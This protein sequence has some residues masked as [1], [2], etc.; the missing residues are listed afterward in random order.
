MP[1]APLSILPRSVMGLAKEVAK[2][3]L[4]RPVVGVSAAARTSDGRWLLVRRGDTGTWGLPGGTLEW[5]ETL[6]SCVVREL[7]EEA[8]VVGA[9]V[10]RLVGVYSR[11]DRDIRFHAVT[12]LV[13]ADIAE[14]TRK[15][16]N[17]LEIREVRLF[18]DDE[19]PSEIALG[20][21]DL[22]AAARRGEGEP[23]LE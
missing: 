1:F 15:P 6:R 20:M 17:P 19:L 22:L 3:L 10:G 13:T 8:G 4:R 14:P 2:A 21:T 5:G 12:V 16:V 23:I 11:P 18:R 7:A 9:T